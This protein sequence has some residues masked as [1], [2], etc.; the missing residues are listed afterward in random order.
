MRIKT[1]ELVNIEMQIAF[2][3]APVKRMRYNQ[4][5]MTIA[6]SPKNKY[7][8]Y[9]KIPS[10]ISIMFCEF[11]IFGLN[12]PI[13]EIKRHVNDTDIVSDN[14]SKTKEKFNNLMEDFR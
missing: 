6:H 12:N 2:K 1:G 5:A 13:Y 10:I 11:D 7:F 3:N 9:E 14:L 8:D 4:S